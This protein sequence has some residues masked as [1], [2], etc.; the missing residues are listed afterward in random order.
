MT[1]DIWD[2][3]KN[4]RT[5]NAGHVNGYVVCYKSGKEL[6]GKKSVKATEAISTVEEIYRYNA[7]K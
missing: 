1:F 7:N 3:V 4:R 2:Y 5:D 6:N